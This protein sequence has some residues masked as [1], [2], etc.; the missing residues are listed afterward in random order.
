MVFIQW[1]IILLFGFCAAMGSY[2]LG[3]R[4]GYPGFV[5]QPVSYQGTQYSP[6]DQSVPSSWRVNVP[7]HYADRSGI[8]L[9][10]H[11]NVDPREIPY[12]CAAAYG[13]VNRTRN[14]VMVTFEDPR[15]AA[16]GGR[17]GSVM[18]VNAGQSANG[19]PDLSRNGISNI[20]SSGDSSSGRV[21]GGPPFIIELD[22]C[23]PGQ[24][25]C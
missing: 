22:N 8:R 3:A 14:R 18:I 9:R 23:D 2:L 10:V 16:S 15:G 20:A 1:T 5:R 24:P 12:G 11:C 21:P 6:Y 7:D 4:L 25:N 13:V 17:G 19:E